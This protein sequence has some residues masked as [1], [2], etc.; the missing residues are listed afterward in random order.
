[1]L[2]YFLIIPNNVRLS[3]QGLPDQVRLPVPELGSHGHKPGI[4]DKVTKMSGVTVSITDLC[5]GCGTCIQGVCFVDAIR[6][7]D[8]HAE[9]GDACRGCGRCVDAYPIN[10]IELS[11][12]EDAY[13]EKTIQRIA[14][15]VDLS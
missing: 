7:V 3:K 12:D 8:D 14:Q 4:G 10:S 2:V 13:F 11:I 1:M 5:M 15:M 6:L 9:I